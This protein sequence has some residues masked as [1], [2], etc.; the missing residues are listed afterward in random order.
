MFGGNVAV[1]NSYISLLF[2]KDRAK[3]DSFIG[4][5]TAT[6]IAS[7]SLGGLLTIIFPANLFLPLLPAA[8]I[9][10]IALVVASVFVLE[11][12]KIHPTPDTANEQKDDLPTKLDKRLLC[13][14]I[15]GALMDN[16]GS[17]GITRK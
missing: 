9:S 8:A 7:F 5:V 6:S 12:S 3:V 13:N 17:L 10:S 14:I 4:Y 2:H 16:I 11:P 1:A 15:F